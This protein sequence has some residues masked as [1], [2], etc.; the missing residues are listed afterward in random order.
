MSDLIGTAL[1]DSIRARRG[2]FAPFKRPVTLHEK[3]REF[4][5]D[6]R[7]DVFFGGAAGGGKTVAQLAAASK[8][9]H[10]PGYHALLAREAFTHLEQ[11]NGLIPLSRSW[12][13]KFGTY[14][15]TTAQWTFPSGA[16]LAFGHL[17]DDSAMHRI[18]GA[19]YAYIGIDEASQ[20]PSHRLEFLFSRLRKPEAVDVPLR[21]RLSS[22]P[23]GVSHD[24]LKARYVD[25]PE[26]ED[27]RF[28]PSRVTDNPSLN[29]DEYIRSLQELD[30][31]T[32]QRLLDGDWSALPDG[33]MF[34]RDWFLVVSPSEVPRGIK[35]VRAWDRAA[36]VPKKGTDPDWTV[37]VKIGQHK[38]R[39]YIADVHRFRAT[40]Q[41]NAERI[42]RI[43]ELD[44]RATR[45]VLEEEPGSA[46][47]DQIDYY[48]REVLRGFN[49][50]SVR[51]TGSKV[52]RAGPLAS[53]VEAGNVLLVSGG[54]WLNDF[55][56]ELTAF[57]QVTHDDQVDAASLAFSQASFA[58]F[59]VHTFRIKG[60]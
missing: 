9:I 50:K 31:L 56:D 25:A 49:L 1:R 55:V 23:G 53:A 51:S 35:W 8:N 15:A 47:K 11:P 48:R 57:P 19:E 52:D 17:G 45:I 4:Y 20:I 42:R 38:G 12:F 44:T 36:S 60:L 10:I 39:F 28:I 43:A 30:P 5:E 58:P 40:S 16:K 27:R 14:N 46:G 24:W 41:G 22:N 54:L 13:A 2:Q 59:R 32:R 6:D 37:G 33:G 18:M 26:T 3:Q 7:F 29:A 21:Y 34:K